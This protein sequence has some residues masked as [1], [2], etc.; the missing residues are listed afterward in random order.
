M[1]DVVPDQLFVIVGR[2]AD[3]I[4]E[5]CGSDHPSSLCPACRRPEVRD[6][7]PT[8]IASW[9]TAQQPTLAQETTDLTAR[10]VGLSETPGLPAHVRDALHAAVQLAERARY[11]AEGVNLDA[12]V[13]LRARANRVLDVLDGRDGVTR[14]R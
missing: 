5:L 13:H 14:G 2:P 11:L 10:L 1:A 3:W 9:L 4:C 7:T 12:A 8:D 6:P